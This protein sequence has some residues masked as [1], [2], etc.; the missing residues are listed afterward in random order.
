MDLDQGGRQ[1]AGLV[2]DAAGRGQHDK[3]A[4]LIAP[5]DAEQ[6]RSLVTVLAVQVDQTMPVA[7]ATGPA[8]VC[9]LAINAAAPMFGTTPEAIL[10]AE[11]SRPVSD[12]RA[13]AM[14]AA[15]E[16]GLSLPAIAEH[17]NKD[18]GSVI[19]AVR[20]TAERP[21]LADAA[22]R[23]SGHVN[24][25]YTARLP[26]GEENMVNLHQ[27]P[28]ASTFQPD[29]PVEHAVV[30]AAAAFNTTPEVLLS[31]D[32]SRVAADA[33]AVAMTAARQHGHSLPTIARHFGRDHT[34]V[35]QAT[36]RIEK[37]PP[38]RDLAAKITAD[39]P[40]QPASTQAGPVDVDE[41]VPESGYRSPGLREQQRAIP[42]AGERAQL[43]VAR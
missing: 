3:V 18:H 7:S 27:Q 6:L 39:L 1:L 25:R 41:Q 9:E 28:P 12:A 4:D 16:T 17:F 29:G 20:R 26:R 13:V 10:S 22:A 42:G 31:A 14:T 15:R 19:H 5:L 30:A 37:T 38:L 35:L 2:L 8:A 11:R 34:T 24:S 32:R 21:R 40:E 33:R 43:R 36:R 23:V